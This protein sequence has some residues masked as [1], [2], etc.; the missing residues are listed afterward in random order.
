MLHKLLSNDNNNI[1]LDELLRN[2]RI[3]KFELI[4]NESIKMILI[5]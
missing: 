2:V 1:K 4:K 5:N 3:N